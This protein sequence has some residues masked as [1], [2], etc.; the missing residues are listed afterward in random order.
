MKIVYFAWVR[1][2]T[3]ISEE[4]LEKL[5]DNVKT[6]AD[7]I[8][9]QKL[10]GSGFTDAFSDPKVIRVAINQEYSSQDH[11]IQ[12]NDEVAFFPPVTGGR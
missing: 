7:L 1:E 8:E 5:P 4:I 6:V 11:P 10:R 9:W 12:A 2:K 3:G